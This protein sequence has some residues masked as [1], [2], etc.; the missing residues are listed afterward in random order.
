MSL[1]KSGDI[2]IQTVYHCPTLNKIHMAHRSTL[3]KYT[4]QDSETQPPEPQ[5]VLRG[6]LKYCKCSLETASVE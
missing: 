1:K 3:A 4:E 6:E 5:E 2:S